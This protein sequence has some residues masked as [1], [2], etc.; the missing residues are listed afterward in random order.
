MRKRVPREGMERGVTTWAMLGLLVDG[1]LKR[2]AADGLPSVSIMYAT[3]RVCNVVQRVQQTYRRPGCVVELPTRGLRERASR[4]VAGVRMVLWTHGWSVLAA[5]ERLPGAGGG[6]DAVADSP[7]RPEDL[8]LS[9]VKARLADARAELDEGR[10]VTRGDALAQLEHSPRPWAMA[11]IVTVVV[12]LQRPS[13]EQYMYEEIARA[14]R[15]A[16]RESGWADL[17][18][19]WKRP[20]SAMWALRSAPRERWAELPAWKYLQGLQYAEL[21]NR[22]MAVHLASYCRAAM[23][24]EP[25]CRSK[26]ALWRE[27]CLWPANAWQ[28]LAG[29]TTTRGAHAYF[30]FFKALKKLCELRRKN[31]L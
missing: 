6:V 28:Q 27:V 20:Q 5:D 25:T 23:P 3:V 4:I 30:V 17:G 10:R 2:S 19:S 18:L 8:A 16:V 21:L 11:V 26:L 22:H 31:H 9:E 29:A 24:G 1:G 7:L 13:S 12:D 15:R 14:S